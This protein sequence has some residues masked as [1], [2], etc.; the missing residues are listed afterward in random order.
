[1]ISQKI[2]Y[3]SYYVFTSE[4]GVLGTLKS[5]SKSWDEFKVCLIVSWNN[6]ENRDYK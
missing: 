2:V 4:N 1:M 6:N 3:I 5:W